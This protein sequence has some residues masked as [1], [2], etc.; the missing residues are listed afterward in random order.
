VKKMGIALPCLGEFRGSIVVVVASAASI[1][2]TIVG[3]VLGS[4]GTILTVGGI[5]LG[6]RTILSVSLS[7]LRSR[8]IGSSKG[9]K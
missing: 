2:A 9:K 7:M 3:H 5:I 6:I 4:V 1:G 8:K